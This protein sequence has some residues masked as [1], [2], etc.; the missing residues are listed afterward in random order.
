MLSALPAQA[1]KLVL[2]SG[3]AIEVAEVALQLRA[4]GSEIYCQDP[5]ACFEPT[6]SKLLVDAGVVAL[7]PA[8]MATQLATN[9][10]A[11]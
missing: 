6:A 10:G 1:Q 7:A 9:H 5:E 3:A 8:E 2:M 4:Q 11:V